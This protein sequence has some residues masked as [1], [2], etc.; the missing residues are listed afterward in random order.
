L[1]EECNLEL[2]KNM[3]KGGV[4]FIQLKKNIPPKR[5]YQKYETLNTN[6]EPPKHNS[7]EKQ[8]G[9]TILHR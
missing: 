4:G 3:T 5:V 7:I 6:M 8:M 1:W 2:H 9:H